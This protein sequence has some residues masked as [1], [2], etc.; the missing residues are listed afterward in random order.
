M[1][2]F[3]YS[4]L[5][6]RIVEK[7]GSYGVFAELM[8]WSQTTQQKKLAGKIAWTQRD[9]ISACKILDIESTDIPAYF[10]TLKVKILT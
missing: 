9:I 8:D 2:N 1:D 10:F 4:K 6:G 7:C 5:R 3:D